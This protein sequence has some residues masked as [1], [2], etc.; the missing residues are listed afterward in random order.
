[1]NGSIAGRNVMAVE[2]DSEFMTYLTEHA[3]TPGTQLPPMNDLAQRLGI[4]ISKLREQLEV[5]R[6]LGFVDVRP[7][8]GIQTLHSSIL[9]GLRA[10]LQYA[11]AVDPDAFH[12]IEDLREHIES[13]Y[14]YDAVR[15]LRPQDI[16]HLKDLVDRAW[17]KLRGNPIQIPHNEHREL[18]LTVFSRLENPFVQGLLEAYWDAYET[19]GLAVYTDYRYLEQV[20]TA[21]QAMVEAIA[22]RDEPGGYQALVDHFGI[23]QTR[24]QALTTGE[25]TDRQQASLEHH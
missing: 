19:V 13:C 9:P 4:S 3:S 11:L 7:R 1:M 24:P 12:Q 6:A 25:S 8:I 22:A 16:Q 15:R 23:L 2:L 10:S 14:W 5:A 17:E 20:W 18:H 21:H